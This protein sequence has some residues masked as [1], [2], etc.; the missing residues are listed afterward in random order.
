MESRNE[1]TTEE[2]V[3]NYLETRSVNLKPYSYS[4][5]WYIVLIPESFMLLFLRTAIISFR[6]CS[7]YTLCQ[8]PTTEVAGLYLPGGQRLTP[9]TFGFK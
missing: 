3:N 5:Y 7:P 8:L 4:I 6:R 2:M 9:P 1:L